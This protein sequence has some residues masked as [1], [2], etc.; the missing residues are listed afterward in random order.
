MEPEF[1]DCVWCEEPIWYGAEVAFPFKGVAMHPE[2]E[3][4]FQEEYNE[5]LDKRDVA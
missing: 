1:L 4:E 3:K 2:C 5:Y